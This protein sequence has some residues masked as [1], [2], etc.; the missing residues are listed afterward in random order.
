MRAEDDRL[1]NRL[2]EL[3]LNAGI[4]FPHI[5]ELINSGWTKRSQEESDAGSFLFTYLLMNPTVAFQHSQTGER[6]VLS[7]ITLFVAVVYDEGRKSS[8]AAMKVDNVA[9]TL[10][11]AVDAASAPIDEDDLV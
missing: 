1:W 2:L 11:A 3:C 8:Y 5:S 6:L 9:S 10:G 4:L 7:M